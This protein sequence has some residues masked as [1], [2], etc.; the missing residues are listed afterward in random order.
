MS[1][2]LTATVRTGLWA[3]IQIHGNSLTLMIPKVPLG[4]GGPCTLGRAKGWHSDLGAHSDVVRYLSLTICFPNLMLTC[5]LT[6][7]C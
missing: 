6:V 7:N 3:R 5:C 4:S 2:H 1:G